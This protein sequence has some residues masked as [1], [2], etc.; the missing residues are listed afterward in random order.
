MSGRRLRAG[1]LSAE[2]VEGNLRD[3]RWHGHEALR[4]ISYLVRDENW[5]NY[6]IAMT[7]PVI[8]EN[9]NSFSI[10][11]DGTTR[12]KVGSLSG[13]RRIW[14]KMRPARKRRPPSTSS[15]ASRGGGPGA[16]ISRGPR[17]RRRRGATA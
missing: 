3:I 2:F 9:D 17:S 16:A 8:A 1:P 12:S 13:P 10:R 11:Y 14:R 15:S 4:A 5:G 7:E 6:P